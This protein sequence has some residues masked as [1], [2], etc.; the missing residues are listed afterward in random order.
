MRY[1]VYRTT[2]TWIVVLEYNIPGSSE[3]GCHNIF[4]ASKHIN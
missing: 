2:D 3:M 1:Q 4:Q